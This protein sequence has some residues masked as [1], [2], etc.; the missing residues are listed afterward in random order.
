VSSWHFWCPRMAPLR[1]LRISLQLTRMADHRNARSL[2]FASMIGACAMGRSCVTA[3]QSANLCIAGCVLVVIALLT[4]LK[5]EGQSNKR[6]VESATLQGVVRDS[7]GRPLAAAKV[8]LQISG[9]RQTLTAQTDSDGNYRFATLSPGDYTLRAEMVGHSETSFGPLALRPK[10]AKKIDLTLAQQ[11]S[12]SRSSLSGPPESGSSDFFDEPTFTVAGVT[13]PTNLGGHGSDTVV[14]NKEALAKD[15]VSLGRKSPGSS[16]PE[17]SVFSAVESLRETA[18]REPENFDANHRLGEL[19]VADGQARKALPYLERASRLNPGDFENAYE[20]ALACAGA[21]EYQQAG[22]N[23]RILLARQDRAPQDQ[24]RLHHLLGDVNE[25]LANPVEAVHEYQRAAELDPSERN[26][27]DWGSEL[28]LHRAAEPAVEVFTKGNRLFPRS[29]RILVGLGVSWYTRG[30]YEQAVQCLC[31]ASDL[32][33]N[34]PNPYLFL[35]KIQSVE[36]TQPD[37][38]T[39]MLRR[40]VTLQP[41]NAMA[42]YY[43]AVSLWKGRKAPEDDET[44]AQV[45][46][47]LEKAVHL[48]PKLGLGYLQLGILYSE[49]KDF[50]KAISAYQRTIQANPSLEE[51]HYRLAHAYRQTGQKLKAQEELQVYNQIS[52]R[53]A[54]DTERDR[55]E[56]Q[57]FVYTLRDAPSVLQP[58]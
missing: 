37:A 40:F 43:Y 55:H 6:P 3:S 47:L 27:F 42:N 7:Q 8:C 12:P 11:S 26:F 24:A 29:G 44:L 14:R 39:G 10:E 36:K 51:T 38:L 21:G 46:S 16:R 41:E 17:S 1:R 19:L 2:A 32:N 5:S 45:Q 28:L 35:G 15:T 57:Q 4:P 23:V 56:I 50:P 48:D 25:R 13:D 20:L 22:R 9:G 58:Q 33:P 30:S 54:A 53:K 34:D 52:K 18:E 49:R 31:D